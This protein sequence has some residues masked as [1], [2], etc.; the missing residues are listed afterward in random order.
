MAYEYVFDSEK[1]W[2]NKGCSKYKTDDCTAGYSNSR[3]C[4]IG[5]SAHSGLSYQSLMYLVDRC[6][7]PLGK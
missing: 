3:T 7:N 5:L 4:E 2:Y 6:A 1:C